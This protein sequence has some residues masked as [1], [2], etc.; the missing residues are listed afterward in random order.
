MLPYWTPPSSAQRSGS[1]TTRW[2]PMLPT[3]VGFGLFVLWA[4]PIGRKLRSSRP[5]ANLYLSAIVAMLVFS[6][7]V[8]EPLYL[9]GFIEAEG[10]PIG[11]VT[12]AGGPVWLVKILLG[13]IFLISAFVLW[14]VL[15]EVVKS[16][17]AQF[18][19]PSSA[20]SRT[21]AE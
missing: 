20:V 3:F 10:D 14:Q 12:K 15:P 8:C 13:G 11:Y 21:P 1:N 4:L 6:E 16:W 5:M 18:L 9:L 2:G 19:Q 17:K 7:A